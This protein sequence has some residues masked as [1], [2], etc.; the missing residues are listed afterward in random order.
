LRYPLLIERYELIPDSGGVGKFRGGLG[1][2]KE[3]RYL[4]GTGYFTNRSDAQKFPAL[5]VLGGGP[6]R[7]SAHSLVRADG[8]V[9]R[10]PSKITNVTIAAGD[11]MVLETA[12]GGGYGEPSERD[13]R[14]VED[15]LLDG[16]I[17]PEVARDIYG[18][19]QDDPA[20]AD[21]WTSS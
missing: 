17:S 20:C 9:E 8:A 16:K 5:G 10:L 18:F 3:I 11:L 4:S 6:G 13:R 19:V 15:D 2:R 14:R 1:L 7:P 12:G 21:R